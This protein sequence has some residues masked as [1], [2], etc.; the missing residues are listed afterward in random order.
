MTFDVNKF[1][2]KIAGVD[3]LAQSNKF[4]VSISIPPA[5][6]ATWASSEILTFLT[7]ATMMPG[8]GIMTDDNIRPYG[9]GPTQKIPYG[10]IFQDITM[11]V[12]ADNRGIAHGFF[13]QWIDAIANTTHKRNRNSYYVAYK[14]DVSTDIKITLYDQNAQETLVYTLEECF[15]TTLL[16]ANLS[17]ADT[18]I[19]KFTINLSFTR[20]RVDYKK[21]LKTEKIDP[22]LLGGPFTETVPGLDTETWNSIEINRD[23]A[24]QQYVG[25][26]FN[27]FPNID[28][29]QVS[30]ILNIYGDDISKII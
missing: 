14:D 27:T 6:R 24:I 19:L 28:I 7:D 8:V 10:A 11:Q 5:L 16:D 23:R 29:P 20:W 9:H 25:S 17:W 2:A 26:I 12:Y 22:R 30:G 15:P 3:G 18:S 13:K 21:A 1:T 4:A